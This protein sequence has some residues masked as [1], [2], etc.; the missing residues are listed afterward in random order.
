M[1]LSAKGKRELATKGFYLEED[2]P[3]IPGPEKDWYHNP[4]TGQEFRNLPVDAYSLRLYR[5]KGW[6]RGP[7]SDELRLAW[8]E[9]VEQRLDK[10][11]TDAAGV[12][13]NQLRLL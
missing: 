4:K 11:I 2:M 8:K 3:G 9:T 12:D 13:E 5:G 6:R 7:A 1:A 10:K